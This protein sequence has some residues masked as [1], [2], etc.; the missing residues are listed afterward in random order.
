MV[1]LFKTS[2]FSN[3]V[4]FRF[5]ASQEHHLQ[6][7]ATLPAPG[8]PLFGMQYAPWGDQKQR[9]SAYENDDLWWFTY[10]CI[11]LYIWYDMI[12]YDIYIWYIHN[13]LMIVV[14]IMFIYGT[15]FS[16][17]Q[18]ICSKKNVRI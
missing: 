7:P 4:W 9:E 8:R 10:L 12:W 17:T 16:N 5:L 18:V 3:Q 14:T 11:I 13:M 2:V 15:I 1:F 6:N